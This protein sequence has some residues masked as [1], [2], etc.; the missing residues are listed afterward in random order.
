[1]SSSWLTF[2]WLRST[3]PNT[4]VEWVRHLFRIQRPRFQIPERILVILTDIF[5]IFLSISRQMLCQ[6]LKSGHWLSLPV[7][8]Y[9]LFLNNRTVWHYVIW[10]THSRA[11]WTINKRISSTPTKYTRSVIVYMDVHLLIIWLYVTHACTHYWHAVSR[12]TKAAFGSEACFEQ[13]HSLKFL[14]HD[15]H[16]NNIQQFSFYLTENISN[17]HYKD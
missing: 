9:S 15:I 14:E 5:V 10:A 1:M 17:L 3:L 7:F 6:Y 16:L 11:K 4:S 13:Q 8:F 12:F 2:G